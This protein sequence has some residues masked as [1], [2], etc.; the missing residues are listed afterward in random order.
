MK[1]EAVQS[2]RYVPAALE[3]WRSWRSA[4]SHELAEHSNAIDRFLVSANSSVISVVKHVNFV[5]V[6]PGN[7]FP[8]LSFVAT[9][10]RSNVVFIHNQ[11]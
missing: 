7:R 8:S 6:S 5:Q 4:W 3:K 2:S 10:T 1:A 11:T 9:G